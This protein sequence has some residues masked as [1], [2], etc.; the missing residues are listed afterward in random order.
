VTVALAFVAFGEALGAVQ[1]LGALA[2]LGAAVIVNL[3]QPEPAR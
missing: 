2:V 1:V 3:P